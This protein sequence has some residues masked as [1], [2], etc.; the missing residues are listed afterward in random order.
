MRSGQVRLAIDCGSASTTGVVAWSDGSWSPLVFDGEPGLP[1]AVLVSDDGSVVTGQQ[2]WRAAVAQP[3][4]F[5]PVPR[6]PA[7]EQVS[8][9]GAEVAPA[10]LVAATLRR[11][12]DEARRIVGGDVED[13]RLVV[14]AGWGPRRRTWLRHVAHRAGLPQPRLVEAPV[15]VASHLRA[16]GVPLP[17]GSVIVV[18]DLGGG[19]EVSVVRRTAVGFE[20]LSTLADPDAGGDAVDAAMAVALSPVP[21][22]AGTGEGVALT[23]SVR[24]AKHALFAHAAVTVAVP[25]GPAV[26]V[27][28]LVL[29]QAARPVLERAAGLVRDAVDAAE[30]DPATVAG[31][32]C[33]GGTAQ[34]RL[35]AEVL[36]TDTG[37]T[38][39]LVRDPPLAA[40]HGAADAGARSPGE[41]PEVV[42]EPLPS[43]GRALAVAVSGF[44]SLALVSHML[45]TPVWNSAAMGKWATL[46]W[47]ELAMASVFA[48]LACLGVGTV[49]GAALAS[50]TDTGLPLSPGAQVAT[51]ILT[52]SWLGVAVACMYA[53]VGSQYIGMELGP[54]LRWSVVPIVPIV[55]VAAV[56]AVI[57][58]RGWRTPVGGWSRFLAFPVSS[59]VTATVGMLVL[60]WSVTAERWPHMLVW[61]DFGG[62]F[63]GLLIGVGVVTALVSR[64]VLR[65]VLGAPAAILIAA[66]AGPGTTGILAVIYAVAVGVWWL[67]RLW[68][69]I[70]HPAPVAVAR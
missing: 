43:V 22:A 1:S 54:F 40:A 16:G 36:A 60:Q 7:E 25:S 56:L 59:V 39:F 5:V 57:A 38:P 19:A 28:D 18:C 13:V 30:V 42:V 58:V 33:A 45:F 34:M 27:N 61:I 70:I 8:V 55:V 6:R 68:T 4:R 48:M 47:G 62:R 63:G 17:V 64:L 67:G 66:L 26:V 24:T 50:R 10:D 15:A 11:A 52:A 41:G 20:I 29:T 46:N 14:P 51:G 65:L 53:V 2:A 37:L 9:A 32:W 35:V 49:L 12:A 31:L 44:A 69:R 3:Q 21:V 23:A